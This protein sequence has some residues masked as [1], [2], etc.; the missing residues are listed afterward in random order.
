MRKV[1]FNLNDNGIC[2]NDNDRYR[3]VTG[4]LLDV[5]WYTIEGRRSYRLAKYTDYY[6]GTTDSSFVTLKRKKI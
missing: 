3:G 6:R 4:L 1:Y 2:V 5:Y